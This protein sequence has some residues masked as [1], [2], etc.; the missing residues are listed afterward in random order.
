MKLLFTICGRAGSKGIKNKNVKNFLDKPL[1]LYSLSVID[2][3]LKKSNYDADIVINTD[4]E[5][6]ME[7]FDNNSLRS[8]D[9]IE[10]SA[11]LAGDKVAKV[12]VIQNC[13]EVMEE[14][15]GNYDLIIDLDITS[16]LRTVKDLDD[17]I[18]KKLNTDY[19]LIFSVTDSRRN[20]YFNMVMETE[21]GYDRV[22]K[23][24]FNTRQEAPVIYDMN[25]SIYVYSREFL[26]RKVGLFDGKC[27][28]HKMF[29]TGV[30]D[31]DHENDMF[32][33]EVIAKYL[34]ENN[35]EFA[36]VYNNI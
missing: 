2:L 1:A 19:D 17:M 15:N 27:G 35:E 24:N 7:I 29:D 16:P 10:R 12:D 20:P 36:E 33:M 28:I 3:Y 23:S 6:L 8:V 34:F 18:E 30:L 9:I 11:D 25:A 5:S 32:L 4:S 14:K 31:L 26:Q 21:H 22:I 13:L